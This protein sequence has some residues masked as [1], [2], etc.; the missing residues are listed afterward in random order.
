MSRPEQQDDA[1][2]A[3][4]QLVTSVGGCGA[5]SN[6]WTSWSPTGRALLMQAYADGL[7]P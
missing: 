5:P 2:D 4:A 3:L 6:A 7:V 1:P